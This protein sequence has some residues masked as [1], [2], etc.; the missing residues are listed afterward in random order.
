MLPRNYCSGCIPQ[1]VGGDPRQLCT[2]DDATEVSKK[3][4]LLMGPGRLARFPQQAG[5]ASCRTRTEDVSNPRCHREHP[6]FVI[7]RGGLPDSA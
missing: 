2:P 1:R 4:L 5:P 6:R 3:I 7:F